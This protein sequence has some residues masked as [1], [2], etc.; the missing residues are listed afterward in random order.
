MLQLEF[1]SYNRDEEGYQGFDYSLSGRLSA[2]RLVFLYR[3]IQEITTY[4]VA[5]ATPEAPHVVTVVDRVG[6]I[7]KLIQQADIRGASPVKLD[8]SL[9]TPIIIVPRCSNSRE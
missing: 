2:V 5:L 8:F 3:F 4:F 7:E 9:D 1:Q 6:G